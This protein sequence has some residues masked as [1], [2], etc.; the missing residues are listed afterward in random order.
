MDD[1]LILEEQIH[2]GTGVPGEGIDI[3][4]GKVGEM[5]ADGVRILSDAEAAEFWRKA[6]NVRV[7]S[8]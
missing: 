8:A 1:V 3:P 7:L 5:T 4:L 2:E 6:K